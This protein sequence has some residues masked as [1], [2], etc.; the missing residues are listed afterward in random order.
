MSS[1]AGELADGE[2]AGSEEFG[3]S[4]DLLSREV[5]GGLQEEN[6][7]INWDEPPSPED[8][9]TIT[10]ALALRSR[11]TEI[12]GED[13]LRERSRIYSIAEKMKDTRIGRLTFGLGKAAVGAALGY[14]VANKLGVEGVGIVV[15]T[16]ALL[17][18]KFVNKTLSFIPRATEIAGRDS[19]GGRQIEEGVL[20]LLLD[21]INTSRTEGGEELLALI[22]KPRKDE[23]VAHN[24]SVRQEVYKG[25]TNGDYLSVATEWLVEQHNSEP[26][27]DRRR[28]T[29]EAATRLVESVVELIG[30]GDRLKAGVDR[31][32]EDRRKDD[33]LRGIGRSAASFIKGR[34]DSLFSDIISKA[35]D[36]AVRT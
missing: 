31:L 16:G 32:S 27:R 26:E 11:W 1:M 19:Y 34:V 10:E 18:N 25:L 23:E 20:G 14:I 36:R 3:F 9:D 7:D 33:L 22:K 13:N 24:R 35:R 15:G 6:V 12:K 21:K 17:G 28:L 4:R 30:V 29:I 5:M 2:L 8:I